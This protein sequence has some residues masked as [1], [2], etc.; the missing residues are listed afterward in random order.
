MSILN[1][2]G[3][4]LLFLDGGMGTLLQERGLLPGQKPDEWNLL[5]PD[6]L[7]EVHRAYYEAGADIVYTNTFG[8]NAIKWGNGPCS[9]AKNAA[10]AV[11]NAKEAAALAQVG[12]RPLYVALD[13]G[14]TGKLLKPLGDLDFEDC[15]A[16]YAELIRAG[17]QAGADLIA[18]ETMS[19]LY[20]LKA[21]V[22][23]AKENSSL[24]VFATVAFDS[25]GKLLTGGD[26]KAVVALLEGL[27]VDALGMNCGFGPDVALPFLEELLAYS[28]L[29][30]ILKPNAGLPRN[31]G[32]KTVYD[33]TPKDFGAQMRLAAKLGAC[34]LGGCCGT[35]PAHIAALR[36]TCEGLLPRPVAQKEHTLVCSYSHAVDLKARPIVIGER[37]NPTGKKALK[38]ALRENDLD[39][40]LAEAVKQEDQ[41]AEVLDVNVGLPELN[42]AEALPKVVCAVQSV[43]G[44]PLQLD[45]SDPAAMARAMR[46]YNGKPMVNSV[47]G[48]EESLAAILPLV[49]KYGGVAVALTLDEGGIPETAEGRLAI[50]KKIVARAEALG[51]G[52]KNIVVDVLCLSVSTDPKNAQTALEALRLV[53]KE[54]GVCTVL[55]VSNISFGLPSREQINAAFYSMALSCGLDACIINPGSQLMMNA[56]ISALALLGHDPAFSRYIGRFAALPAGAAAAPSSSL[57]L[58]EAV[59]KGLAAEAGKLAAEALN[60]KSAPLEVLDDSVIPALDAVGRH[61]ESGKLFLPQ[62]LMSAEAAKAAFAVL[63]AALPERAEGAVEHKVVLATVKGDIHDIGKNIVKVLLQNYGFAVIDLGKDVPPE[64]VADAVE[65]S[66]AKLVGLSALMTTTVASMAETIALIKQRGL[67]CRVVVGG[68]VLNQEYADMAGADC[69]APDAMATVRYAQAVYG[70]G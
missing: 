51:I 69:Y 62:L 28:S 24:P 19:D 50:A 22:L 41:S 9:I 6:V 18:I 29:P 5:R 61:F 16:A 49:K 53:K 4:R 57:T 52:R 37:L 42:E 45:S 1:E 20:E 46:L 38:A 15:V 17:E 68:A 3:R 54:L 56:H 32:G 43:T 30:V 33:V 58:R 13:V 26:A 39:Y 70:E 27:G 65:Q 40:V 60:A 66:G 31:D 36:A 35:T 55:G 21:A 11:E 67:P 47:N 14:P 25:K 44:L 63:K 23:A 12:G 2:L 10:A 8:S 64:A 34:V 48:K 59:E 7:R